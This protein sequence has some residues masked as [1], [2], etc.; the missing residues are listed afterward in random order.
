M[1][2]EA[3][4]AITFAAQVPGQVDRRQ[5]HPAGR[6]VDQHPFAGLQPRAA[7]QGD[8][9]GEIGGAIAGRLGERQAARAWACERP[10]RGV[11]AYSENPPSRAPPTT[12]SPRLQAGDAT[13][14]S[15]RARDLAGQLQAGD[16]GQGRLELV[17]AA[18]HAAGR[19]SCT[20]APAADL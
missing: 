13:P 14:S 1:S 15:P 3:E 11:T 7:D 17:L 2:S 19:G 16:E 5:A 4:A 18:G 8:I 10:R 12:A 9:G 20:A 6:A